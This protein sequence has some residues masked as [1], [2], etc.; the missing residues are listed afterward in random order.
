MDILIVDDSMTI[1]IKFKDY[2]T[3]Q[4][5]EVHEASN[6]VEAL[7][8]L[9]K[10]SQIKLVISDLNMPVMDGMTFIEFARL[11]E[12]SK[13]VPILVYT[14][15][16]NKELKS[17]AKKLGVNA[18]ISKPLNQDKILTVIQELLSLNKKTSPAT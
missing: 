8:V 17:Q 13:D 10:V 3:E 16:L 4:G 9:K 1:R 12:S 11:N 18:W 2:L 14:T 15:E 7:E 6:G 5:F